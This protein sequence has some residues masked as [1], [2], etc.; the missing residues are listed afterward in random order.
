MK[1]Y[2][3]ILLSKAGELSAISK[4][5]Q[6]V[7]QEVCPIIQVLSDQYNNIKSTFSNWSFPLNQLFLDFSLCNPYNNLNTKD[8][9]ISLVKSGVNII[10]VVQENSDYRYISLL[11][12]LLSGGDISSICLRFSNDSGGFLNVNTKIS[13]LQANLG[14][15]NNQTSLLLDFGY[16]EDHNYNSIAALAVN[17]VSSIN[18][19]DNYQNV[20]VATGSFLENLGSLSPAGRIYRL[21]RLE[22]NVW[23]TLQGQTNISGKIK[24]SDY[25][26][27]YPFYSEANFRGSCSIKYTLANEFIVY[28]GELSDNHPEG[29]GQYIIFANQLTHSTDY[30]GNS[31]SWGDKQI[32]FYGGQVLSDRKRKTGNAKSWVEISQNHHI[33]LLTSIL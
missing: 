1:K 8:L 29:N 32:D 19:F 22:W 11:N 21:R 14:I 24:Y 31:F 28:R 25:G 33:T 27:K 9:I 12:K 6:S 26:A 4:L 3:P 17:I 2:F 23:Q 7:K 10:P 13:T 15:N 30:Y 20:I 18:N 16:L 5:S